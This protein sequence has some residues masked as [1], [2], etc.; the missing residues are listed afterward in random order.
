MLP[1]L[2]ATRLFPFIPVSN[3]IPSLLLGLWGCG[4]RAALSKR[5]VVNAKHCPSGRQIHQPKEICFVRYNQE[6]P[7]LEPRRFAV[8][9][10]FCSPEKN[11]SCSS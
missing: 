8:K 7:L 6:R 10:S 3:N 5:L 2:Q 9:R 11:P 4:Q 1:T